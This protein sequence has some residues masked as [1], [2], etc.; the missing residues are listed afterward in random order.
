MPVDESL[1][2]FHL[3]PRGWFE[4]QRARMPKDCVETWQRSMV[5]FTWGSKELVEWSCVWTSA[6]WSKAE[7]KRLRD[8]FR[9]RGRIVPETGLEYGMEVTV[10]DPD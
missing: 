6:K 9:T 7:R 3:T 4:G 2:F 1:T 5:Q 8:R 10:D